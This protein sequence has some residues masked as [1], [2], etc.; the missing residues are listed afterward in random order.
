MLDLYLCLKGILVT[1]TA[2][3]VGWEIRRGPGAKS[4]EGGVGYVKLSYEGSF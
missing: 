4:S 2:I 3:V 1:G